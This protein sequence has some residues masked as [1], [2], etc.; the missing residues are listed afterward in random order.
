M[1]EEEAIAFLSV[2]EA[3]MDFCS[4]SALRQ[5]EIKSPTAEELGRRISDL[6]DQAGEEDTAERIDKLIEEISQSDLKTYLYVVGN[7]EIRKAMTA[8]EPDPAGYAEAA[9]ALMHNAFLG[10][11]E[12]AVIACACY[13]QIIDGNIEGVSIAT[14][15]PEIVAALVTAGSIKGSVL[16]RLARGEM[17]REVAEEILE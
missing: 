10:I 1:D 8:E 12:Y 9:A 2:L 15:G 14:A 13:G 7:D 5:R 16:Q 6:L 11:D 17:D 3:I 4:D